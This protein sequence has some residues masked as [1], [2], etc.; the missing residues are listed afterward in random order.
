[1]S[2]VMMSVVL[3]WLLVGAAQDLRT[4]QVRNWVTLPALTLALGTRLCLPAAG[5][6]LL[7]V[8]AM[9]LAGWHFG[10]LGGADV[11]ALLTLGLLDLTWIVW[12]LLGVFVWDALTWVWTGLRP[13]TLPAFAGF[14]LGFALLTLKEV[15]AFLM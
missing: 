3:A 5:L 2:L 4:R 12:A 10:W 15:L 1:M 13:K 9:L 7:G 6:P 8:T 11:K 14:A